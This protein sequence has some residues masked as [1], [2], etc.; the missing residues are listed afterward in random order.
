MGQ[1]LLLHFV[2][3]LTLWLSRWHNCWLDAGSGNKGCLRVVLLGYG[4]GYRSVPL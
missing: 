3:A 4:S 2:T 1:K